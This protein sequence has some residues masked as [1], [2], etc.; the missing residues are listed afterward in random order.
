[1]SE[2][3]GTLDDSSRIFLDGLRDSLAIPAQVAQ[4]LEQSLLAPYLV[5]EQTF[6]RMA[7]QALPLDEKTRTRLKRLGQSQGLSDAATDLIQQRVLQTQDFLH[8]A[9]GVNYGPLRDLLKAGDWRGA[10]E[11]TYTTMIRAV[12]KSHG[13]YFTTNELLTFPCADLHTVDRLWVKYSQGKFGFSVQKQIYVDCGAKLDGKYPG[14]QIW[15]EFCDRVGWRKDGDY[16]S[17]SSLQANPFLSPTGELP[18][19]VGFRGAGRGV[20]VL[21]SRTETCK[22]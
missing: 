22:L 4:S 12:G 8:S 17:Y 19:R 18:V 6:Q 16:L 7:T 3:G 21:F 11:E 9:K 10:D 13:D 1:M 20:W 15:Y 5:Y 2:E 14:D